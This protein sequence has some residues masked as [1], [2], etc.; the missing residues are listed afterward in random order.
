MGV[1]DDSRIDPGDKVG[2]YVI[3]ERVGE[4]GMG[5][6]YAAYDPE[7]DRRVAL[8]ILRGHSNRDRSEQDVARLLREARAIARVSHPNV[9]AVF[10]VDSVGDVMFIAM[11]YV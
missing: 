3:L 11:E 2:R 5:V 4:G 10:D 1:A 8:K 7:L 9:I 6:V